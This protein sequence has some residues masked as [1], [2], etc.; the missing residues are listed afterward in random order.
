MPVDT[1]HPDYSYRKSDWDKV[2]VFAEGARRVRREGETYLPKIKE[3]TK[4]EYDA[5]KSRAEVYGAVDRTID[6]LDG[7]IFRKPPQIKTPTADDPLLA[8]VTLSGKTLTEFIRDT[9]REI[10]TVGRGGVLI[11]FASPSTSDNAPSRAAAGQSRP[12]VIFYAAEDIINWSTEVINGTTK[13]TELVL[14]ESSLV[15]SITDP[16]VKVCAVRYRV[17]RLVGGKVTVEIWNPR[18]GQNPVAD[19]TPGASNVAQSVG[20]DKDPNVV[21]P[22]RRGAPLTSIPFIFFGPSGQSVA[23]EKP[24]LLDIADLCVHHYQTS[25]DYAHGLHW[26]ALPTP[27]VTGVRDKDKFGIGPS[28]AIVLEDPVAK[29]GMLEFT[30]QGLNAVKDRLEGLERKMAALGA[31]ILEEQKKQAESGD[32]LKLRQSGDASVLAG[33]SDAISRAFE[34][35]VKLMLWWNGAEN[36]SPDVTVALNM[37]FFGQ[38]MDP[39]LLTALMQAR[40]SGEISRE[41]FLWNLQK[42]EMLPEGRTI[43]DEM[44]KIQT[45]APAIPPAGGAAAGAAGRAK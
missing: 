5:Y 37:E 25:A 21:E 34:A 30:G 16:F 31:R 39:Q 40:Q 41:T 11:D 19:T 9:V 13:L 3:W 28:T 10:L 42:G 1:P 23:P 29:C 44:A 22:S 27:W 14:R 32:A 24:P 35:V 20:F 17:L 43:E 45:E 36:E 26:V 18:S 33:I 38:P 2:R 4:E 6:G 7:A 15:P 8:D 12:Y